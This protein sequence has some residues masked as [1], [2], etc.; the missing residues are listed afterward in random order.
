MPNSS[1]PTKM[2]IYNVHQSHLPM[3][4]PYHSISFLS[5]SLPN[6]WFNHCEC[7]YL[8]HLI[9]QLVPFSCHPLCEK[10]ALQFHFKSV[11]PCLKILVLDSPTM[12]KTDCD[13]LLSLCPSEFYKFLLGHP[14]ASFTLGKKY[15]SLSRL[16]FYFKTSR[17]GTLL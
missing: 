1:T 9:W 13:Y 4:G 2:P 8:S 7:T 14:S 17:I 16:S 10:H 12:G 6:T 5:I 15:P 3:F 11:S